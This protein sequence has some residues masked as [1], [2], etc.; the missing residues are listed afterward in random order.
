MLI[1]DEADQM[2]SF[3]FKEQIYDL[4]K[5]LTTSCQIAL[6]SATLPNEV[7]QISHKFMNDPVKILV[8]S[9]HVNLRGYRTVLC[10]IR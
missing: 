1:I 9:G 7:E 10:C 5:Y 2:L 8:N 4:C 3:G 6:Y